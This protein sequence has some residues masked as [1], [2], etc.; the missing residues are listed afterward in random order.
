[1]P[2]REARRLPNR[3]PAVGQRARQPAN[4][5]VGPAL[6]GSPP[7]Q[8][9]FERLLAQHAIVGEAPLSRSKGA[10]AR[11]AQLEGSSAQVVLRTPGNFWQGLRVHKATALMAA[12][13][14]HPEFVEPAAAIQTPRG[15]EMVTRFAEG[16]KAAIDAPPSWRNAV[17]DDIRVLGAL[18]DHLNDQSDKSIRNVILNAEGQFKSIDNDAAFGKRDQMAIG[19]IKGAFYPGEPLAYWSP[20]KTVAHLPPA[21][22][23][24]VRKLSRQSAAAIAREYGYAVWEAAIVK[25]QAT[26]VVN[27][28]LTA[29]IE[30][31]NRHR[32]SPNL[33]FQAGR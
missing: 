31:S 11:L 13:V 18:L 30:I 1:M 27:H 8:G 23:W 16:F 21:A 3:A 32:A 33:W 10:G 2:V 17:P 12:Q 14:G 5:I 4:R 20:Q 19:G 6:A 28:G 26:R 24:L 15:P 29:A 9:N 7:R 25:Q 22:R